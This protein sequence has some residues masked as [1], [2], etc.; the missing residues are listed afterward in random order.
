M[1]CKELSRRTICGALAGT[2]LSLT[3][4]HWSAHADTL[5]DF[6][7]GKKLLLITSASV[8]GGYDQYAR[9]LARHMSRY[10]P[11]EPTIS[12][13]NMPGAEGL[14]AANHI[15]NVA[16]QDGTIIGGLSRN[17]GLARFYDFNNS[18]IQFDARKFHWLGSPQQ[19][20]GL[21]I[22]GDKSGVKSAQDLKTHA[23]T[24]SSTARNSPSSIYARMLNDLYGAKIKPIDGYDGSQACLLAV[25][26][27]EVDGHISGGSSAPFRNRFLPWVKAGNVHLIMQ[28]GMQRDPAFP[29]VPT[30]LDLMTSA[31]DKQ[32]FEIAFA[33]QVMGRPFVL[34]PGVPTDRVAMLRAAFDATM[35]DAKFLAEA[36]RENA[37]IDPVDGVTINALL[38]RVYTAP[39]EVVER[40]RALAK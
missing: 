29:D 4:T 21:L 17:T 10:I 20:I 24:V 12:V 6:Y 30:A 13:Q 34:G 3:G 35:K 36:E 19:E 22:V 9:L 39:P 14:K 40:L 8:G 7:K 27:A 23:L 31:Q 1:T 15:Y 33:E 25:E 11:G 38:D 26:R 5:A 28:M 16:P 18:G 2:A 32:L 37:E